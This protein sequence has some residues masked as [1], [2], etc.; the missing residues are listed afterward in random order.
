MK[1]EAR[2]VPAMITTPDGRLHADA[3]A[4]Q[5]GGGRT[6]IVAFLDLLHGLP[7]VPVK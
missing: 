3:Q 1:I 4:G 7:W 6:G 2:I 5:D